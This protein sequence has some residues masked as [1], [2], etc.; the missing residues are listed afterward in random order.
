M[1]LM[2]VKWK[3]NFEQCGV[4]GNG[5]RNVRSEAQ[6]KTIRL[7]SKRCLEDE[8]RFRYILSIFV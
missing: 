7:L 4:D 1:N 8:W 2:T 3:I 5:L 6:Q